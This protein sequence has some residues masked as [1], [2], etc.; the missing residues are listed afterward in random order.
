MKEPASV[1]EAVLPAYFYFL[2]KVFFSCGILELCFK[3]RYS[4]LLKVNIPAVGTDFSLKL[5]EI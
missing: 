2:L 4:V 3:F 5:L 1:K